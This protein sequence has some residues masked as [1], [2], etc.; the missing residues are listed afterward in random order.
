[1]WMPTKS[2]GFAFSA[3]ASFVLATAA[4]LSPLSTASYGFLRSAVAVLSNRYDLPGN[5][6][7]RPVWSCQSPKWYPF[8]GF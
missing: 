1:M 7:A 8:G 5:A 2:I 4:L 6:V 3:I